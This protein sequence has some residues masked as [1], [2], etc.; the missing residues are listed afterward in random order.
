[1]K[2]VTEIQLAVSNLYTHKLRTFL[3]M[4]GMIFGVGAV[5]AMLSI[6]AGAESE[7]LKIIDTMG[8]RNII[9][10]D[11]EFKEEDLKK[12]RENSLGLS[13]RDIQAI[14][15]V[16]P[17]IETYSARKRVKTFQ[18]FSF[19]GK[20]DDS[21]VIGVTPSYF[22]IARY[23]L[24]E[25]SFFAV[26]DEKEY[27]QFCIIGS[28]I[29]Q[30][31]FGYV[32]PVGQTI[33]IDKMWFTVIGV[34]A[35]HNLTKDEFEGVKIQDFSNDIYIPLTTALK[36]FEPKRFES[37]LDEIIVSIKDTDALKPSA[38]LISQVLVNTHG[39]AE[40]FSI[41]VPRELLEQNQRTQRIFNI[42][43]S[44][45]A[46]ISLLVGGIGIMN[47]MLANILERTREIGVRRAIGA[48][49]RDIWQQFLIEALTI[50]FL[51]G[52][53]G[54]LFGFGVSRVVALYAEWSTVVTGTSIGMSF[55]VSA[56]VG[57]IFGIYPAVRAS[58][59]DP[60][61]ALRYE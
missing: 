25:G 3:T 35:D 22:R 49:R 59:L 46:S 4:L 52:L 41:I 31:L 2:Y 44:C 16:T 9:V 37:E 60:V 18:I 34:L 32:S 40:D 28:R 50:S 1:M 13:L 10:K 17:E 6:G 36:K 55:G 48:R 33:K 14:S 11:R 39:K 57:L 5:I 51:G 53:T 56:A 26:P 38:V 12:I 45:I 54:I 15:A 21:N 42:V 8:L 30:K 29:K 24:A 19:K 47:I 7:S 61:E 20:S 43:M 27:E 58:R 23:D